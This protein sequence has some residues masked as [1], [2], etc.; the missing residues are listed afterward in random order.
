MEC[1]QFTNIQKPPVP[2]RLVEKPKV[3]AHAIFCR[4]ASASWS[5]GQ[6]AAMNLIL[7]VGAF[8]IIK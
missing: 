1:S 4:N 3:I 2:R 8:Q 6:S 7:S 5:L